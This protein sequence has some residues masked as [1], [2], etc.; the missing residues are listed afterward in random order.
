MTMKSIKLSDFLKRDIKPFLL[1]AF[2]SRIMMIATGGNSYF[3]AYTNFRSSKVVYRDDFSF[4]SYANELVEKY[5][6]HSGFY[7]WEKHSVKSSSMELRFYVMNDLSMPKAMFYKALYQKLLSSD[8]ILTDDI[9]EH[10]KEFIRGFL[11]L[12]GSIDTTAKLIAQDY[13]Y[14]NRTELKKGQILTDMMNLPIHFANFN[15]RNLQPQYVSGENQ[16]NA[17]FRVN[18]FYYASTIGFINKYKALVFENAYYTKGKRELDG[19]I[20]YIV[21][22]PS[23]RNEDVAFIRY[24]NFFTNNIYE[25]NLTQSAVAELRKRMG[26]TTS[27]DQHL[28]RN[29]TIIDIYDEISEDK[30][31][32]CGT[33]QTYENKKTGRQYFEIHHMISYHNGQELDNIANLVKLCPNCHRMMKRNSGT[34]EN[35]IKAILKILHEHQEIYEFTSSYL[36]IYD[37]NEL[38]EKIWYMLG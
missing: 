29:K 10:K 25:K 20:Y 4:Y 16:R 18:V 1:G 7:N 27:N 12:R 31:A 14:D 36:D 17:Q 34:K 28:G 13:F 38:S 22:V 6:H 3:Y 9:N 15:A 26:F 30:C 2:L 37:I 11:E 24:L 32:I 35:Q 5:N 23:P 8:W 21:D 19:I 33:K